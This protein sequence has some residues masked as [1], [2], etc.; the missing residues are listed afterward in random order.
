MIRSFDWRDLMILMRYRE[1]GLFLSSSLPATRGH[2][3]VPGV[4]LSY[5]SPGS[6][7]S[8]SVS[9]ADGKNENPLLGQVVRS[10]DSN[11]A[12]LSFL[13]PEKNLEN[14]ALSDLLNHLAIKAGEDGAFNLIAEIDIDSPIF[15]SLRKSGFVVYA[16]QRL[17]HYDQPVKYEKYSKSWDIVREIDHFNVLALCHNLVPGIVQQIESPVRNPIQGLVIRQQNSITGFVEFVYGHFGIWAQPFIHPDI[18][19][20]LKL[21]DELIKSLPDRRARPICLCVRSYQSW[22][23]PS[24]K[25][26]GA[27]AGNQQAVMVKRLA[28]HHKV[29]QPFK[30]PNLKSQPDITAPITGTKP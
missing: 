20:P 5:L 19:N 1:Q 16:R 3:I 28:I 26:L 9:K 23:E 15:E 12:R 27:M 22:L 2:Q 4:L 8:T 18:E 21:L 24:M 30:I 7:I 17:W 25:K 6:G 29:T 10:A 14:S 13:A 11:I